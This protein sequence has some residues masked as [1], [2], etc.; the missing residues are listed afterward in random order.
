M[1]QQ[2]KMP[3]CPTGASEVV[4]DKVEG[5]GHSNDYVIT[6]LWENYKAYIA[7]GLPDG[8]TDCLLV[9]VPHRGG[10]YLGCKMCM[11]RT[12][13]T[14]DYLEK[15]RGSKLLCEG[16]WTLRKSKISA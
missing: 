1:V 16:K 13:V 7:F 4:V 11:N 5:Q 2:T 8:S 12:F 6:K 10:L 14:K 9:A 15:Q 3:V